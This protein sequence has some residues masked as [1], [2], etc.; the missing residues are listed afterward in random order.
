MESGKETI[1]NPT[2]GTQKSAKVKN[3]QHRMKVLL[4]SFHLNDHTLS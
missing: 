2:T 3:K 4:N 1:T